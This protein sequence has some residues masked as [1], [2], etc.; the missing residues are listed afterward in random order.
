MASSMPG[1]V[2]VETMLLEVVDFLLRGR[3]GSRSNVLGKSNVRKDRYD[4]RYVRAAT[5]GSYARLYATR[6]YIV[7]LC[8][9]HGCDTESEVGLPVGF[10][11]QL[12]AAKRHA[13][14]ILS[15]QAALLT[16]INPSAP[17]SPYECRGP[18]WHHRPV[19]FL[20]QQLRPCHPEALLH[21]G[22][23]G[24]SRMCR[25]P[26]HGPH[27][28]LHTGHCASLATGPWYSAIVHKL[29]MPE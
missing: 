28:R 22:A 17:F 26:Q 14:L 15:T 23:E 13:C 6:P 16:T 24:S 21:F 29:H 7:V 12:L 18:N 10:T 5:K 9:V 1:G 20:R 27:C 8:R 3:A 4:A 11:G 2:W 25:L 19:R